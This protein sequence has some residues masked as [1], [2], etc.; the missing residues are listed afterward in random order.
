MSIVAVLN[1]ASS[2]HV[3][4]SLPLV[5]GLV[6][7]GEKV[8][9]YSTEPYRQVIECTGAEY[10]PYTHPE[11]LIPKAHQGAFFSVMAHFAHAA[12]Q[13]MPALL[14]ELHADPPD[15]LLVDSMCLWG[16]LI[17]QILDIPAV[18]FSSIF[19]MPPQWPAATVIDMTQQNLARETLVNGLKSF[20]TYFEIAQRLDRQY[21]TQCPGLVESFSNPQGLNLLFASRNFHPAI[22]M[23]DEERYKFIGPSLATRSETLDFPFERLGTNPIIYISLGTIN[24]EFPDFF[25]DCFTAFSK[26]PYQIIMSIGNK[27]DPEVL[28]EPPANFIVRPYVPQLEILKHVSLFI[29]HGGMNSTCEALWQD[30]PL[31]V[32]PRR[33]D[34]FLVAQQVAAAGAGIQLSAAKVDAG[35]LR[36]SATNILSHPQYKREAEKLGQSFRDAGGHQRGVAEIFAYKQRVGV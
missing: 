31:I 23:F 1:L 25:K 10:R 24:T 7:Q 22:E 8:I 28:G 14:S 34:Q 16:N 9:Y 26:S 19:I 29:T 5:A 36:K 2:G 12:E 20:H 17:Q 18:M 6:E 33:G 3:N 27:I 21:G 13:N 11:T 32:I 35:I 4:P 30:I 15:Y